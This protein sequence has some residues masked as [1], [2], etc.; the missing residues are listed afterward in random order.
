MGFPNQ[1]AARS[2]GKGR[3]LP[4]GAFGPVNSDSSEDEDEG[5]GRDENDEDHDRV[6][7]ETLNAPPPARSTRSAVRRQSSVPPNTTS[8]EQ[9]SKKGRRQKANAQNKEPLVNPTPAKKGKKNTSARSTASKSKAAAP[10]EPT[11]RRSKRLGSVVPSESGPDE[12]ARQRQLLE[13][14][15][16]IDEEVEDS[17]IDRGTRQDSRRRGKSAQLA[18]TPR[19]RKA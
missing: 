12:D 1:S 2:S 16:D 11:P 7:N 14:E 13:E 9:A 17:M 19:S 8:D 4:P 10:V 3:S 18:K 5:E 6:L 15:D